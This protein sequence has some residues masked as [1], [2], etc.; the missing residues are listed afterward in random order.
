R[1]SVIFLYYRLFSVKRW[2]S[3]TLICIGSLS[4]GWLLSMFFGT[5]FVCTPVKAAFDITVRGKCLNAEV[6]YL[7]TNS[8]DLVFDAILL[9]LPISVILKL[10]LPTEEKVG[11]AVIFL[12]G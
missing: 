3:Y 5:I 1:L 2:L 9:C 7:W 8:I 11:V 12:T 4:V 6:V 10:S